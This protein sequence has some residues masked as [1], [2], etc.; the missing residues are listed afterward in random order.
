MP[1]IDG[2]RFLIVQARL[3]VLRYAAVKTPPHLRHRTAVVFQQFILHRQAPVHQFAH[4]RIAH[5]RGKP[6]VK[7]AHLYRPVGL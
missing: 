4:R 5:Q 2:Y 7:G 3:R 6:A 1:T